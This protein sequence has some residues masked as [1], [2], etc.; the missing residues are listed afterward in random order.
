VT[1][2]EMLLVLL[3]GWI[4]LA[5]ITTTVLLPMFRTARASDAQSEPAVAE[6]L[7]PEPQPL[8]TQTAGTPGRNGAR[9]RPRVLSAESTTFASLRE[10]GYPGIV[11]ERLVVHASRVLAADEAC[12]LVRE[13]GA[14]NGPLVPAV[15]SGVDPD[16]IGRRFRFE[17]GPLES[18]LRT[19]RP[20]VLPAGA[21]AGHGAPW[22]RRAAIAPVWC[23]G[24]FRGA[25]WVADAREGRAFGVSDLALMGELA[26]LTGQALVHH[27]RQ[28]LAVADPQHEIDGLL[29]M[30]KRAEPETG[31]RLANVAELA[32]RLGEDLGLARPDR[33]EL[34]LGA[35]LHDVGKLRLPSAVVCKRGE[36][37]EAEWELVRL[38]PLWGAGMVAAIPGLEAVALV[39]R[40]HHERY[41]GR[42][43]P[44]GLA[45]ERI[46]LPSRIVAVCDAYCAMTADRPYRRAL[47]RAAALNELDA[48]AGTQFD[49]RL[50][51]RLAWIMGGR[52]AVRES[53]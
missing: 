8:E 15:G 34:E 7:R 3:A 38:H 4:A 44:D 48:A 47:G 24:S 36:L 26:Q 17:R 16:L 9:W 11:L 13:R 20:V 27:D 40:F 28:E 46:P 6:L 18:A 23:D 41:D 21:G 14:P 19:G 45:G 30:L 51:E 32:R 39:V 43:Y 37:T 10:S 52:P 35:R 25:L 29:A 50:V 42:G 33:I 49:P 53:A 5:L 31:A 2:V 22:A 12:L 1:G